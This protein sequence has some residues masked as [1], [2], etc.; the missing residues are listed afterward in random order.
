M[1]AGKLNKRIKIQQM[2]ET[3][4]STGQPIVEWTDLTD[5]WA[6]VK[7][8]NGL[9]TIKSDG[10]LNIQRAS[11]R[12]RLR[13]DVTAGMRVLLGATI[14]DIQAVLPDEEGDEFLDLAC[15]AGANEG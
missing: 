6:N 5:V 13:R 15:V 8:L 12:I 1:R 4:D 11:I 7:Y 10:E 14:F 2:T 9:Q 3:Q